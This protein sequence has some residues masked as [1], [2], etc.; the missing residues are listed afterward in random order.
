[1]GHHRGARIGGQDDY[2]L[3]FHINVAHLL[4]CD[5]EVIQ[6]HVLG[7][8]DDTTQEKPVEKN[9]SNH[10]DFPPTGRWSL[11]EK[12][13]SQLAQENFDACLA[14]HLATSSIL[15]P[16]WSKAWPKSNLLVPPKVAGTI[17]PPH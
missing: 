4:P 12:P 6:D 8:P 16:G 3:P 5:A 15:W 9:D 2:F 7:V 17:P 13:R 1:M 11:T 14:G 10:M